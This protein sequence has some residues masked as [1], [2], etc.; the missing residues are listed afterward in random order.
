MP[1]LVLFVVYAACSGFLWICAHLLAP[2]GYQVSLGRCLAAAFLLT[3][4]EKAIGLLDQWIGSWYLLVILLA[5]V[6]II[7]GM[8]RL[9]FW[10]SV[11]ITVI[12]C[13]VIG[14]ITYFF[15]GKQRPN[16]ALQRL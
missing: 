13:V 11:L 5:F 6:L 14:S 15:I 4:S 10:R 8:L 12:Y 1:L 16:H 7:K 9:P 3:A 2:F